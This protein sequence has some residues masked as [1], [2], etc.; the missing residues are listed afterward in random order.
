MQEILPAEELQKLCRM[1]ARD[2]GVPSGPEQ[3]AAV[4]AT[5]LGI[6]TSGEVQEAVRALVSE[7]RLE[8]GVFQ[9]DEVELRRFFDAVGEYTRRWPA[10]ERDEELVAAVLEA[11]A[12]D[13][14]VQE[15][16]RDVVSGIREE[17][18]VYRA[19]RI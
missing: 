10:D 7:L 1:L 3:E 19:V 13:A 18:G 11:I 2:T 4:A 16:A 8:L 14:E 12:V 5:L 9:G 6:A 15:A 17:R